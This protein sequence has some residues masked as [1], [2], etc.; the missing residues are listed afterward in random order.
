MRWTVEQLEDGS[1]L[2][3]ATVEHDG[4]IWTARH[5]NPMKALQRARKRYARQWRHESK[6]HTEVK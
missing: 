5:W 2:Y 3:L 4:R 6:S 1:G